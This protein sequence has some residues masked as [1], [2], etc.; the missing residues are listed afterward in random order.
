MRGRQR[1]AGLLVL[2]FLAGCAATPPV[3]KERESERESTRV[4]PVEKSVTEP[5]IVQEEGLLSEG[6][7]L[8]GGSDPLKARSAFS[9]LLQ[10]HPKSR[11][12]SA[13]E[14]FIRLI[15]AAEASRRESRQERLLLERAQTEQGRLLQENSQLRKTVRDLTERLQLETTALSQENDQLKKDLQRLKQLEIELQKRERMLR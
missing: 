2:L 3:Q 12:R 10:R 13:A 5:V 4:K 15:D 9:S 1:A 6:I 7:A 8:L 14:A 11:W